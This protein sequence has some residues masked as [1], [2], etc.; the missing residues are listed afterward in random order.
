M[1]N[2]VLTFIITVCSLA[3][4]A[5]VKPFEV[6]APAWKQLAT[7]GSA[8]GINIRQSPS[9]TAP[10]LMYDEMDMPDYQTPIAEYAKWSDRKPGGTFMARTFM[11]GEYCPVL[12]N[13]NG[14]IQLAG[15][16]PNYTPGWVSAK[17]C[18][19]S[20]IAPITKE[21][22]DSSGEFLPLNGNDSGYIIYMIA[23]EMEEMAT[24]Y[25]GKALDGKIICPY[26]L[27]LAIESASGST[28][29]ISDNRL[30]LSSVHGQED[31]PT[32]PDLRK[33]PSGLIDMITSGATALEHPVVLVNT[34]FGI[35]I[36]N[37]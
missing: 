10:R 17:Y 3:S 8:T 16:G 11:A 33:L 23:D 2:L 1:K 7:T 9:A 27:P 32:L 25:I 22:I 20:D 13:E 15:I 35:T 26:I 12:K 30:L 4:A 24:F 36:F 14:W 18:S 21:Q 34:D 5:A 28:T 6:N 31:L 37:L 19:L 29:S